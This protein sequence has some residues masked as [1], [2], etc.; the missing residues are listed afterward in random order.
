LQTAFGMPPDRAGRAPVTNHAEHDM[1]KRSNF[2]RREADFYPTPRA[3][4]LPLIPFLRAVKRAGL[5]TLR[6]RGVARAKLG[7]YEGRAFTLQHSL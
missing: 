2:E 5:I 6:R 7:A 1:G 4:V 3:A